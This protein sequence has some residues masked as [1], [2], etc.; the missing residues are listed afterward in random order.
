MSLSLGWFKQLKQEWVIPEVIPERCVHSLCEVAS[1][2]RCVDA[3]PQEAWLLDD[4]SLKIDT[5]RC[6]GCGLCVAA[7]T[8]SALVGNSP[9]VEVTPAINRRQFLRKALV[10]SVEDSMA[11]PV[12]LPL[13]PFI[14]MLSLANC[15]GCDACIKLCPHQALQL[16]KSDD[17]QTLAYRIQAEHCTGCGIC[18][19]VCERDAVEVRQMQPVDQQVGNTTIPLVQARCKA[20]GSHFHYP[21]DGNAVK[22]HCRIC[23]QTNHH[24]QLF[25]VY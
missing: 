19:D 9:V 13:I 22:Q 24:R 20:C 11:P 18:M 14:P 3:C 10:F 12:A 4:A 16:E 25:Q 7:C 1:C 17:E 6:D 23:A 5:S 2:T 15:N 8:E 21:A